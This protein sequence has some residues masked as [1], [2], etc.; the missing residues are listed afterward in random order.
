[1][2]SLVPLAEIVPGATWTVRVPPR[3]T[4]AM[5]PAETVPVRSPENA[6]VPVMVTVPEAPVTVT[7]PPPNEALTLDAVMVTWPAELAKLKFPV[8]D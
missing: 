1:M 4:P 7:S 5:V 6:A 2:V 8:T 3:V